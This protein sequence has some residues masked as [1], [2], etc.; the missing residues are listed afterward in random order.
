MCIPRSAYTS[1]KRIAKSMADNIKVPQLKIGL[2]KKDIVC[3]TRLE[4][5]E[6]HLSVEIEKSNIQQRTLLA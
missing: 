5:M 1:F 2:R 3:I 6:A 4:C